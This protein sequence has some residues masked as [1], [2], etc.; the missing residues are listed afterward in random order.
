[1][2]VCRN[3]KEST[4]TKKDALNDLKQLIDVFSPVVTLTDVKVA[5]KYA[6]EFHKLH[7][8]THRTIAEICGCSRTSVYDFTHTVYK[9]LSDT[10]VALSKLYIVLKNN[11]AALNAIVAFATLKN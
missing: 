10:N 3:A 8:I 1:M 9:R 6:I 2:F 11:T 7:S 5:Q 4:A